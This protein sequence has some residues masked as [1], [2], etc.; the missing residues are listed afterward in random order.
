MSKAIYIGRF[1]PF[2]NGHLSIIKNALADERIN[3]IIVLVGS[4]N[5]SISAKNPFTYEQRKE[6]IECCMDYEGLSDK[7][8]VKALNDYTYNLDKW[9]NEVIA[10]SGGAEYIVGYEKD[11]SSF[12]L[13][14]FKG[15]EYIGLP[16]E[17]S[18]GLIINATDI[19]QNILDD[20]HKWEDSA[21]FST[22][23]CVDKWV[24]TENWY[25]TLEEFEH[26]QKEKKLFANYPFPASLNCCT[27]DNVVTYNNHILLITRKAAPGKGLLAL[28][29]GHKDANESFYDC[30][31]REL[32]E[33]TQLNVSSEQLKSCLRG[34]ELFDDPTRS[35]NLC[36]PTVA[37]HFDLSDICEDFPEVLADDDALSVEWVSLATIKERQ[38]E[39]FDD[40]YDIITHFVNI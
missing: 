21:P 26:F 40:H 29:G 1:Q 9:I 12:Y 18:E 24:Y 25:N 7:V 33:E 2:H 30:A 38:T 4:A 27:A 19:R 32:V 22:V 6:M 36:K 11:D 3:K 17:K 20:G 37:F 23:R 14:V 31:V 10:K 8:T 16:A 39:F 34:K 15:M 5:K 28:P 13:K 35:Q